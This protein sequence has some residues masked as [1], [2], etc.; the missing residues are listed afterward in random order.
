[1]TATSSVSF[2]DLFK[3]GWESSQT[4]AGSRPSAFLWT[5]KGRC[6]CD[7]LQEP[8]LQPGG[9]CLFVLSPLYY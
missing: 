2:P 4:S 9:P 8:H 1:M 6:A 7:E 5:R 3:Y